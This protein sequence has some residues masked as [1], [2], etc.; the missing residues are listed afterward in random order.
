[1]DMRDLRIDAYTNSS[2]WVEMRITHEPTGLSVR[3]CEQSEYFLK[4]RLV[5]DLEVKINKS[6]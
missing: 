6:A 1:M 2:R 5:E 4:K 3:G